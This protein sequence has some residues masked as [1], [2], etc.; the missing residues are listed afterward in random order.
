MPTAEERASIRT[1]CRQLR[2]L[3]AAQESPDGMAILQ[4]VGN[5]ESETL[6]ASGDE[7]QDVKESLNQLLRTLRERGTITSENWK[8]FFGEPE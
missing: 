7:L 5:I 2:K 1:M 6:M 4:D 8:E 3:L